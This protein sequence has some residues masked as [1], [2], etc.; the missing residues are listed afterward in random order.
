MLAKRVLQADTQAPLT[1][2]QGKLCLWR[3]VAAWHVLWGTTALKLL[4]SPSS[5]LP[6]GSGLPLGCK[7]C[8]AAGHVEKATFAPPAALDTTK[9]HAVWHLFTALLAA[10]HAY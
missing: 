4:P 8:R 9:I 10:P 1:R 2:K 6:A 5:A 7:T 3:M